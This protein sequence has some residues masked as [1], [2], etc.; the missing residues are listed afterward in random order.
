MNYQKYR[1]LD[2]YTDHRLANLHAKASDTTKVALGKR[3]TARR[4][5][6]AM[7]ENHDGKAAVVVES[8]DGDIERQAFRVGL[9][10]GLV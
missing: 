5:G 2:A 8:R 9:A 4:E 7:D 10:E 6:A 1:L 3:T